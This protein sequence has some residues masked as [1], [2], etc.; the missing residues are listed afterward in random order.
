MLT[1]RASA[2]IESEQGSH[3]L[4]SRLR[5]C[6]HVRAAEGRQ[7]RLRPASAGQKE[8]GKRKEEKGKTTTRIPQRT[9]YSFFDPEASS[10]CL[11]PFYFFLPRFPARST[12]A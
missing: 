4:P 11:F 7:P 3:P 8:K 12:I 5:N 9:A 1:T 6:A 10:F 2:A